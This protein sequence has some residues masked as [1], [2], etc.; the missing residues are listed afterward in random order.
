M[1][2]VLRCIHIS[3]LCVQS[4]PMDRPNMSD[5]VVMLSSLSVSLHP[6]SRP[7]FNITGS[8]SR[9]GHGDE[10]CKFDDR[11]GQ[12]QKEEPAYELSISEVEAR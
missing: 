7:A 10:D 3:L 12:Q 1:H 2:E 9:M 5:V 4:D 6:P 8:T 11:I